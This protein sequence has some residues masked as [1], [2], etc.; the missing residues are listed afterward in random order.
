MED[1]GVKMCTVKIVQN[2]AS[3]GK[4]ELDVLRE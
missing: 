4:F 2:G 3:K 1:N